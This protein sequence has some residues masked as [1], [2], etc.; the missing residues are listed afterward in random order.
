[1]PCLLAV[2]GTWVGCTARQEKMCEGLQELFWRTVLQVPRGTPKVMLKAET[3]TMKMKFRI[4]KEKL[5]LVKRIQ[6]QERSLAKA[7]Y[8]EQVAMGWPGLAREAEEIC[9]AVGIADINKKSVTKEEV[10]EAIFY[11]DQKEM[12]EEMAK[13]EKLKGVKDED[14]RK[15]QEYLKEKGV[16]RARMAF[17][18]R[19]RM[20]KK[21][22]CNFKSMHRGNLSCDMCDTQEDETQEHMMVCPGWKEELGSLDIYVMRDQIEF[23]TRVMRRKEK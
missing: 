23:F 18:I 5:R 20:V 13:Y 14:F 1:M 3:A 9:K 6:S 10:D 22:K 15:E 21:V 11:A 8:E 4:W 17:R 7:I 19:S 2:A 12:K 16:G